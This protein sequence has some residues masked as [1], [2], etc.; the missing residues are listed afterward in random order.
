[1]EH[2]SQLLFGL[3]TDQLAIYFYYGT[4]EL[5]SQAKPAIIGFSTQTLMNPKGAIP[6]YP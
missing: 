6:P 2:Y 4:T 3:K 5:L 1:M